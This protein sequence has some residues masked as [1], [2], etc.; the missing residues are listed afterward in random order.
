MSGDDVR[1]RRGA[2]RRVD[3]A[4]EPVCFVPTDDPLVFL[5]VTPDG[6]RL[7]IHSG[8]K[9]TVDVLGPGQSVVVG[10]ES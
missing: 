5:A 4:E 6:D 10:A 3:G 2:L 9:L 7:A 1:P 8:D